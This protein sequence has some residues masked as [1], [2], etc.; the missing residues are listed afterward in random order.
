MHLADDILGLSDE[1]L[2]EWAAKLTGWLRLDC[3]YGP[4]WFP[5]DGVKMFEPPHYCVSLDAAFHL[6][7]YIAV[8]CKDEMARL[9]NKYE[10]ALLKILEHKIGEDAYQRTMFHADPR[11]KTE[12]FILVMVFNTLPKLCPKTQSA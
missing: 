9:W 1:I 2:E 7:R 8:Q 5:P 11:T 4:Y 3:G 6:E 10:S 12:A